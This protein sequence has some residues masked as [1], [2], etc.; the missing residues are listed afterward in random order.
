MASTAQ[1]ASN[2]VTDS[3]SQSADLKEE[4]LGAKTISEV[5]TIFENENSPKIETENSRKSNCSNSFQNPVESSRST[6]V[7]ISANQIVSTHDV[8]VT[9]DD[10]TKETST[11]KPSKTG[12]QVSHK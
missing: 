11:I 4:I 2:S 9:I 6:S 8:V 7:E 10:D 3:S 12:K 1:N 5:G